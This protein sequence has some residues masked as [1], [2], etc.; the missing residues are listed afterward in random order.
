MALR[1]APSGVSSDPAGA[2]HVAEVLTDSDFVP[3]WSLL[4]GGMEHLRAPFLLLQH[5]DGAKLFMLERRSDD[6]D[7]APLPYRA[8]A[9]LDP[10][11]HS[12]VMQAVYRIGEYA[13]EL[14]HEEAGLLVEDPED[15]TTALQDLLYGYRDV[16][17][18]DAL[19]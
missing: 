1:I 18:P 14:G 7:M 5:E 17:S 3:G 9:D 11:D 13:Q 6:G 4:A 2:E 8:A 19:N 16:I 12:A 10:A 15:E